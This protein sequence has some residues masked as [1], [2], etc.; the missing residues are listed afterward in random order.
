M[1]INLKV[2]TQEFSNLIRLAKQDIEQ[3]KDDAFTFFHD[4]TPIRSGNA[5]RRT[6]ISG[7][8]IRANYPYAG[9]LDEGWSK[10]APDGMVNPT[11]DHIENKLIPKA[12]R[13][14]NR[15]K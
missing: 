13:R 11:I 3:V 14:A 15:G 9:R 2:N 12:I 1:S 5:R 7:N 8:T 4:I 6:S 10:Q